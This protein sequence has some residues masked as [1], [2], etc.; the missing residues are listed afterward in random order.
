MINDYQFTPS[1]EDGVTCVIEG[2][3]CPFGW[4]VDDWGTGCELVN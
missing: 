4:K 3:R 2:L 1:I